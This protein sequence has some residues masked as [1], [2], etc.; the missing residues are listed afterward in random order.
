[1]SHRSIVDWN[2]WLSNDQ[3]RLVLSSEQRILQSFLKGQ[4]G[5]HAALIG[6][7]QQALLLK[8][9]PMPC[10][11]LLTPILSPN[12][13]ETRAVE[14][15]LNEIPIAS[16]SVDFV[17]LPH[18]L[19][20]VDNARQ[21]L[22]EAC[23]IV[24]PEGYLTITGFNPY[25]LWA[26]KSNSRPN[27]NLINSSTIAKWLKLSDFELIEQASTLYSPP[28]QDKNLLKKLRF[29]EW[30]GNKCHLP[31]A[32]IYVLMAKAKVIPLTPIRL[33][34]KQNIAGMRIPSS[35][36]GPTIRNT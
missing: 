32:G 20:L 29:L 15:H 3:G 5:K 19:E 14:C 25:S 8:P 12:F 22:A 36:T 2:Q 24:K 6:V 1:M 10:Q 21:L 13:R 31:G 4:Y 23:R 18:T 26:I 16:G 7:P 33:R 9:L 17:F 28:L 11:L 34:W 27:L 35:I 30:V